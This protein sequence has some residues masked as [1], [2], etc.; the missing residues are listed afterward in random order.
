MDFGIPMN[1]FPG[2]PGNKGVNCHGNFGLG[3]PR[4]S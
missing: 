4:N 2:I 3:I 1:F